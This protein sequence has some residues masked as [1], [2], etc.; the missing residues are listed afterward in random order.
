MPKNILIYN[1]LQVCM[2]SFW[3]LRPNP[4]CLWHLVLSEKWPSDNHARASESEEECTP[5][6]FQLPLCPCLGTS[7][8]EWFTIHKNTWEGGPSFLLEDF[9]GNERTWSL[10]NPRTCPMTLFYKFSMFPI[11]LYYEQ[12]VG[13][14]F[15]LNFMELGRKG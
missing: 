10:H 11:I 9:M 3:C 1:C 14:T 15:P 8:Q 12:R 2:G 4:P 6:G 13:C 5:L 7:T